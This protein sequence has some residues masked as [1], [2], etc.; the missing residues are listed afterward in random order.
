MKPPGFSRHSGIAGFYVLTLLLITGLVLISGCVLLGSKELAN[1]NSPVPV[2]VQMVQKTMTTIPQT[3]S[4]APSITFTT[5][6]KI[7]SKDPIRG[8]VT[9]VDPADYDVV[10]YIL[11]EG[12]WGPKPLW[13][14][15]LTPIRSDSTWSCDMVTTTTDALAT[16]VVA[17]IVPKGYN[18]PRLNGQQELPAE[19]AMLPHTLVTR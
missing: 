1:P 13:E 10:V 12:W 16:Q 9:G 2:Q 4:P 15:P 19:M 17:Y 18:P 3:T 6:P 7:G 11:V 5:V 8:K 14:K